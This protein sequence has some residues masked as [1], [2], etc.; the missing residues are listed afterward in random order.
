MDDDARAT[1]E[2]LLRIAR[3]NTG[4]LRHVA[5]FILAWWN[6]DNLGGFDLFDIFT[7]DRDVARDMATVVHRLAES[8]V[9][10][11]PETYRAEIADLIELWRPG[12]WKRTVETA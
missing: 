9:A 7:V 2:R 6:A 8:P 10:E 5:N 4:Q 3:S 11:Y 12:V 1:F